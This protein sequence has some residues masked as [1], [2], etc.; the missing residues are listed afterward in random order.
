M[1]SLWVGSNQIDPNFTPIHDL[2]K[3][4]VESLRGFFKSLNNKVLKI[5]NETAE[6]LKQVN[7]VLETIRSTENRSG[8][9]NEIVQNLYAQNQQLGENLGSKRTQIQAIAY[10]IE[11]KQKELDVVRREITNWENR[12]DIS[13]KHK[14]QIAYTEKL[15][16]AAKEFQKRFQAKRTAELEREILWMWGQLTHKPEKVG[17][18]NISPDANFEIKLFDIEGVEDD[19]TKFSAGEKEI[20]A[21]SLLWALVQVSGKRFP[22]IID[23]PFGRLDSIHR[24]NMIQK[25]LPGASHQVIVLSQDEEIV[26]EY[27][28]QLKPFIAQELTISNNNGTSEI[29]SGY[30]FK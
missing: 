7:V 16:S 25:Y 5:I 2:R 13:S 20:Y 17:R 19:K 15:M 30:P 10:E 3:Q 8:G 23:T 4:E 6:D 22:I 27:Y 21:I 11:I 24:A 1:R 26:D 14:K 29:T 18:V 9:R 12:S 28:E